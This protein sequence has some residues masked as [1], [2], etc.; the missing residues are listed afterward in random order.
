[1][2]TPVRNRILGV[3]AAALTLTACSSGEKPSAA[4]TT[5]SR[6]T[7]SATSASPTP[8]PSPRVATAPAAG[9]QLTSF[10]G[11]GR[12][13]VIAGDDGFTILQSLLSNLSGTGVDQSTISTYDVAGRPL[14][15]IPSGGFTGECGAADVSPG[16]HRLIIAA[17]LATKPAQ[18]VI[19]AQYS[20]TLVAY[21]ATTGARAWSAAVVP[22]QSEQLSC[23][24]SAGLEG[25]QATHDGAWGSLVVQ[26]GNLGVSTAV[27]LATGELAPKADLL[28][29]LGDSLVTGTQRNDYNHPDLYVLS[30]P[31]GWQGVGSFSTGSDL[32]LIP[33]SDPAEATFGLFNGSGGSGADVGLSSDATL[34]FVARQNSDNSG[35]LLQAFSLPGMA[36]AWEQNTTD[37]IRFGLIGSGGDILV[38]QRQATDGVTTEGLNARTGATLWTLPKVEQVCGLSTSQMLV[39]ANDQTAV[40]D[41]ATGKQLSFTPTSSSSYGSSCPVVLR[42]GIAASNANGGYVV[43]QVLAP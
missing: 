32:N 27:N 11:D 17:Q 43:T 33:L 25:F 10:S 28:G 14:A 5:H 34:L 40:I 3:L 19:A 2:V 9:T 31:P 36:K 26:S 8:T 41:L 37:D 38:V 13:N 15:H 42:G 35:T 12:V 1:V 21:D 22:F 4:S 6:S 18:G 39:Q 23:S 30:T 24:G 16:G 29:A 20:K 7:A